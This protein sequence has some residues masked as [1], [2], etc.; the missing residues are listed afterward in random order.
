MG[1]SIS[2]RLREQAV[3]AEENWAEGIHLTELGV[4]RVETTVDITVAVVVY[5]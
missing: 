2:R 1:D 3:V 4:V 5:R